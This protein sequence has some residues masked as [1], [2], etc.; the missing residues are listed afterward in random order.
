MSKSAHY[1]EQHLEKIQCRLV[2]T[3]ETVEIAPGN[4]TEVS[5]PRSSVPRYGFVQ[6]MRQSDGTYIPILK[7]WSETIRLRESTPTD[8]GLDISYMT[9]KRLIVAGF[10]RGRL[11]APD[12]CLL[13]LASLYEHIEGCRDFEFWTEENRANY[14]SPASKDYKS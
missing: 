6:L 11:I 1:R 10:I 3:G 12:T 8:L 7:T 14:R 4:E 5:I 9:L 13:D 2:K